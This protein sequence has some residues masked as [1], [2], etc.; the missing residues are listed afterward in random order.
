VKT[1]QEDEP[2]VVE[3]SPWRKR[4]LSQIRKEELERAAR[5]QHSIEVGEREDPLLSSNWMRRTG[6]TK[7][8]LG[9]N[10][11]ILVA[12][13]RPRTAHA[14]GSDVDG[15]HGEGITFSAANER[16]LAVMSVAIDWFLDRCED[17]LRHTDH[18]LR[19]CLRSHYPG[20]P[21]SRRSSFLTATLHI[22]DIVRC[23]KKRVTS[24]FACT[25]LE[26]AFTR[27]SCIVLLR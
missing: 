27:T 24:V 25:S 10:R 15:E 2:S 16:R 1:G 12:L 19:C 14:D 23:G 6:W 4:R 8:F 3:Q 26:K 9:T 18:S 20:R 11:S 13:S 5:R 22:S 7:L 21:T 17:T